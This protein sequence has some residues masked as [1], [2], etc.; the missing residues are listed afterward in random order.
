V[1]ETEKE[2]LMMAEEERPS[3]AQKTVQYKTT[4]DPY[5][6]RELL[7]EVFKHTQEVTVRRETQS[8]PLGGGATFNSCGCD[9]VYTLSFTVSEEKAEQVLGGLRMHFGN[10]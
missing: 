1:S 7:G 5:F 9:N 3:A 10:G 8:S 2:N 6:V 4:L